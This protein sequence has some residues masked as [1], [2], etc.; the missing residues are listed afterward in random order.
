MKSDNIL[1]QGGVVPPG[2][3]GAHKDIGSVIWKL[4]AELYPSLVTLS[5][6]NNDFK[7]LGPC[8]T[9]PQHLSYIQNLSLEGNDLKWT[10]DLTTF[11][12]SKFGKLKNLR[13]LMLSGNPMQQNAVAA[14]NEENYRAEVLAN[15]PTLA[16]LDRVS[17]TQKE[18]AIAQLPSTSG[19]GKASEQ[20]ILGPETPARNFLVQT[21]SGFSDEA[22]NGIVPGFL[23]KYFSLFD[24][25]RES[26]ELRSAYASN[27]TWS[28]CINHKVP[29]RAVSAG[30][31]H[32]PD[33]P[34]QRDLNWNGYKQVFNHDIMSLGAKPAWKGFPI[35]P[36][37]IM[38]TLAKLPKTTHPLTDPHK[39][40]VDSWILPNNTVLASVGTSGN[41]GPEK[42]EALLF[43]NVKGEFAEAPSMGVRSFDRTFVVAPSN[44][45]SSAAQAGWP[46]VILS[47]QLTVRHYSGTAGWQPD[48]LPT[49]ANPQPGQPAVPSQTTSTSQTTVNGS[50]PP[51]SQAPA[52][53]ISAEQHSLAI[54]F[55]AESGLTYPYALQCLQENGW[56]PQ[57][58]MGVFQN[59]KSQGAIPP[60]AF[61]PGRA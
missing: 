56:Q 40:V 47:E 8:A 36:N 57:T 11:S 20:S 38:A 18:T 54:Q 30:F 37:P 60:E 46:C 14:Q 16:L 1:T 9:L 58:A 35:G 49:E 12:K 31:L 13:E 21:R 7:T 51:V 2:Q 53:D 32:S 19:K 42:P 15:F 55:S 61:T 22:A 4:T 17:V 52:A 27:A 28:F 23:H 10:K 3:P 39:F 45:A 6:A 59:L 24:T 44:P 25:A 41:T 29:P 33:M 48:T 43:I 50:S 26:Q 34:R 5:L